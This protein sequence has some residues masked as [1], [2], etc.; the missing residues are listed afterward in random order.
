MSRKN[1]SYLLCVF[2]FVQVSR[3]DWDLRTGRC[4]ILP[5]PA[6]L[7]GA[8]LSCSPQQP[9]SE[10][11]SCDSHVWGFLSHENVAAGRGC[12]CNF[13][14]SIAG[15]TKWEVSSISLEVTRAYHQHA[16]RPIFVGFGTAAVCRLPKK[17]W[18]WACWGLKKNSL[19]PSDCIFPQ[20]FGDLIETRTSWVGTD[21]FK[22]WLR[23][24]I[25]LSLT[26]KAQGLQ[27]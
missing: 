19:R 22:S 21:P 27:F 4:W 2:H 14:A 18:N 10:A 11:K 3:A 16:S 17:K 20:Y 1:M 7:Q 15:R 9:E 12:L 26:W 6:Q 13:R 25:I 24:C 8:R 23:D 5:R